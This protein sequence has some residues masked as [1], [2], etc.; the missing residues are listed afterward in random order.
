MQTA[1]SHALRQPSV[2]DGYLVFLFVALLLA[3]L[4]FAVRTGR[5]VPSHLRVDDTVPGLDPP[6]ANLSQLDA[7]VAAI[8]ARQ[9]NLVPEAKARITWA[10]PAHKTK[11]RVA[12]LYLH[13]FSASRLE[14]APVS[15]RLAEAHGANLFEARI[16]GHGCGPDAL[17][18]ATARDWLCSAQQAWAIA[19]ELGERVVIV[20][21][22]NGASL[23]TWLLREQ[24][25]RER[26]LAVLMMAP[27]FRVRSPAAA[28]LSWPFSPLW[29]PLLAGGR[30]DSVPANDAASRIWTH[31]YPA[32][33]LFGMQTMVKWLQRADLTR[34]NVPL[35]MMYMPND[36]TVSP[37]ALR[38]GFKRWGAEYKTL[39]AVSPEGD[40]R[41]HVFV[42][43]ALAPSRND[44]VIETF[45]TFLAKLEPDHSDG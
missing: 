39:V 2:M 11:T 17:G 43:D 38:A 34:I 12:F 4:A 25:N 27:N 45:L 15:A 30:R 23:A 22:S 18:Q 13:G 10:N 26:T 19:A 8:E 21:M 20:A 37:A 3:A 44:W 41:E 31:G 35:A 5:W 40:A 28:L 24:A 16:A 6:P 36:P 1:F 42:G 7:Y 9:A 14:S 32:S 33:A 29:L